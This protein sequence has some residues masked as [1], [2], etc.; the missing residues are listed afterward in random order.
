ML[1]SLGLLCFLYRHDSNSSNPC[2]RSKTARGGSLTYKHQTVSHSHAPIHPYSSVS[3]EMDLKLS[4][5]KSSGSYIHS[6][7]ERYQKL[8]DGSTVD[9]TFTSTQ[10]MMD[11]QHKQNSGSYKNTSKCDFSS[12][13]EPQH[14]G[15]TQEE[16]MASIRNDIG[17]FSKNSSTVESTVV[18]ATSSRWSKFMNEVE[19]DDVEGEREG[20]DVEGV[21]MHMLQSKATVAKYS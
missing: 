3:G 17:R 4:G 13:M 1:L 18:P 7:S 8:D 10:M 14:L 19:D 21:H 16:R 6:S 12:D 11:P 5:R 15:M 9:G 20:R 2:P